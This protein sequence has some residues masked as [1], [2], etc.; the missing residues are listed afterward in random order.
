M[1]GQQLRTMSKIALWVSLLAMFAWPGFLLVTLASAI[2]MWMGTQ[3]LTA[4]HLGA[5]DALDRQ[6]IRP[7]VELRQRT[8]AG[9][10]AR[11][12]RAAGLAEEAN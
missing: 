4:E 10:L 6:L 11:L 8:A 1:S 7:T 5:V 12:A 2:G 3:R 9:E